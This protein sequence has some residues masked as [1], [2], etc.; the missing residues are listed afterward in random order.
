[1]DHLLFWTG[2]FTGKI[3]RAPITRTLLKGNPARLYELFMDSLD[4]IYAF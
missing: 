3:G 1:M 4:K 2:V